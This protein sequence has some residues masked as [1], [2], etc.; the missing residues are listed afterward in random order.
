MLDPFIT[1]AI[2]CLALRLATSYAT[3]EIS[4]GGC[5]SRKRFGKIGENEPANVTHLN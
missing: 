2:V 4:C 5:C 1:T 3:S